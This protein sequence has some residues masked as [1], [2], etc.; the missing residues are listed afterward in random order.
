MT[1]VRT[2][3]CLALLFAVAHVHAQSR[4]HTPAPGSPE[5]QAVC[6]AARSFV[7]GKYA[8]GQLPQPIVFRIDH[9]A[10]QDPYSYFEATPRFKDGSYVPPN[11]IA[12]IAYNLCLK[13]QAGRWSVIVDLSRS[14][15]PDAAEVQAIK[16]RLPRDFPLAVFSQTWRDLLG[17][18]AVKLRE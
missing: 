15:V 12:D 2:A 9:I 7:V 3:L 8:T 17:N 4:P 10:V 13:R 11:L 14:D 1:I 6:D 18:K 16:Q 5:R